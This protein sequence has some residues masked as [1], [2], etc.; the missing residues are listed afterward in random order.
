MIRK[1][2]MTPKRGEKGEFSCFVESSFL[3]GGLEVLKK[4]NEE[5]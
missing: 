5:K 2:Q 4:V 1:A 3:S